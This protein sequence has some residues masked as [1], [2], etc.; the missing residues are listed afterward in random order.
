ME[1]PCHLVDNEDFETVCREGL[2]T[3]NQR[4]SYSSSRDTEK[5]LEKRKPNNFPSRDDSVFLFPSSECSN[6]PL[7]TSGS[8]KLRVNPDKMPEDCQCF[9]APFDEVTEASSKLSLS[10]REDMEPFGDRKGFKQQAKDHADFYWDSATKCDSLQEC[11]E[12]SNKGNYRNREIVCNCKIPEE[13]ITNCSKNDN[14]IK[15]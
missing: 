4:S 5:F 3:A 6:P 12:E 2:K 8:I 10:K 1:K 7:T 11:N 14:L 13:A 9:H 15:E